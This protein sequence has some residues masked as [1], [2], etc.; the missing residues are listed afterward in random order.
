K[1][2]IPDSAG[3]TM[4]RK[5]DC[6]VIQRLHK[7]MDD[8]KMPFDTVKGY[9]QEGNPIYSGAGIHEKSHIQICVRNEDNIKAY[10]MPRIVE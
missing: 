8:Q 2:K 1:N 9:F 4:L 6:A 7:S 5:L 10:F 3:F